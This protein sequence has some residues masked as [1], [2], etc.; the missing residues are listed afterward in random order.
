MPFAMFQCAKSI[1]QSFTGIASEDFNDFVSQHLEDGSSSSMGSAVSFFEGSFAQALAAAADGGQRTEGRQLL[2]LWL[3]QKDDED[4]QYLCRSLWADPSIAAEL[5]CRVL[6]WAGDVCRY[7]AGAV[8]RAVRAECPGLVLIKVCQEGAPGAIEWPRGSFFQVLY[9]LPARVSPRELLRVLKSVAD[10]QDL[11]QQ[12]QR[13]WQQ[14]LLHLEQFGQNVAKAL[15]EAQAT[16]QRLEELRKCEE[17]ERPCWGALFES[18]YEVT[19]HAFHPGGF[20]EAH[21]AAMDAK[22]LLLLWLDSS[23]STFDPRIMAE[24]VFEAF[25]K[26]YFVFWPG[27]AE[28]WLLPVQ[29]KEML[30]LE[31]PCFVILEPLSVYEVEVFPWSDPRHSAVEWPIGCAWAF[32]GALQQPELSEDALMA[33]MSQHGDASVVRLAAKEARRQ[34][35]ERCREEARR[36]REEQDQEYQESLQKDQ[37][38]SS[39]SAARRRSAQELP[40]EATAPRKDGCHLVL[41][42]PC[43]R[44]A[45]RGFTAEQT[46]SEVYDWADCAG[47]LAALSGGTAFEVPEKFLLATTYP[48]AVLKDQKKTLRQLKLLPSA[49][50]TVCPE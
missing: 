46:L 37:Q 19:P 11:Q 29:L 23:S 6:P 24:E 20:A 42:F 36:L 39:L 33:F 50:L 38:R 43:G 12:L 35:E 30:R 17:E 47:E 16:S 14:Q 25:V 2:L 1:V 26:E 15:E 9:T 8:C 27:D 7:E 21:H 28:K 10:Q 41:R 18:R 40:K 44:R 22:K 4:A 48:K 45:E 5:A 13:Q 3:H 31:A 34:E 32:L 49:V